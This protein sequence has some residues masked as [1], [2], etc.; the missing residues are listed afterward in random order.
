M[1]D[2][3]AHNRSLPLT[4][5]PYWRCGC[6]L[7]MLR[8]SLKR[9]VAGA[10]PA[11]WGVRVRGFSLS[12]GGLGGHQGGTVG[13]VDRSR[14]LEPLYAQPGSALQPDHW[15]KALDLIAGQISKPRMERSIIALSAQGSFLRKTIT[16]PRRQ[17][18]GDS[19]P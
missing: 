19:D 17:S 5:C 2:S 10:R 18:K 1:G 6:G 16:L 3:P 14:L 4:P 11:I 15:E 13:E 12:L 7:T 9:P 8:K